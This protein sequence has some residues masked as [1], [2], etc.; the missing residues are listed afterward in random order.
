MPGVSTTGSTNIAVLDSKIVASLCDGKIYVDVTPSIYIGAGAENVLGAN[1][2]ILN[3]YGLAVKPYGDNYEIAPDLSGAMS[4][5]VSFNIPTTAG[6]YQYGKYTVNVKLFDADGSSWVV[7]KY[8]TLCTPDKNNK[9]R[10]Y[11]SLSA[12][13]NGSCTLGKLFIIVDGV[14]TYNGVISES[15]VLS[16]TLEY[17]TSS[18]L[19]P[20]TVTTGNLSVTLFEGVYKLTGEICATYNI[21]DNV[22]QRVKYKVKR[23]KNIRCLIDKCCV[24]SKLVELHTRIQSD[25]TEEERS[26]TASITVDAL[27]LLEMAELA[28]YCG[29]DP[30]EYI[31]D[32]E[33]LL[34]CKCTCNCAE[35][36]PIIGTN[37]SADVVIEG[38]N[39]ASSENG[40]TTTYT[41]NNYE[42]VVG[43][44]DNGGALIVSAGTL[45]GCTVRQVI[46]FNIATVYAQIKTLS[47]QNN[48][49]ADFWA[50]VVNKSLRDVD[51]ASLGLSAVQWQALTFKQKWDAILSKISTC[52]GTCGA[53]IVN[54]VFAQQGKDAVLTWT[55]EAYSYDIY[56]DGL[57]SGTLLTSAYT[58]DLYSH[59][60]YGIADGNEHTWLLIARCSNGAIGET[61]GGAGT[62][63]A[64]RFLGCPDI[65][66]TILITLTEY[67]GGYS[68][69]GDCPYD[70]GGLVDGGNPLTAEWHTANDTSAATLVENPA[71]VSGG[72]YYVFN[73]DANGCYS[74]GTRVSLICSAISSC[75]AP[76]NLTV[77]VFGSSNFFVQFQSAAYPPPAN[78]YTV[79]RR[80]ASAPDTGGSYTT[81]GNPVW[82]ASL[83]RWVIDDLSAINNTVYVYKAESNCTSTTPGVQVS[84]ANIV[85][86]TNTLTPA[87]TSIAYSLV[88][89]ASCNT[90]KVKIYDSTGTVLIHTDTYTPAFANPLTGTFEYLDY[91]TTYKVGIELYFDNGSVDYV[92]ICG[93]QSVTT[94]GSPP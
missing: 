85:C 38:C 81:I 64:F 17:P 70:L 47:N 53:T 37:P 75:T 5:V 42:Y 60:F 9:T 29:E 18:E 27:R 26:L 44:E 4:A 82:N 6:N 19:P 57:L 88:P 68:V 93:L 87:D 90:I 63:G 94:V 2:E 49:E 33:E 91:E 86:P 16:A 20:L 73:K 35:G 48:T 58:A 10:N 22:Y 14:P 40:N 36:T 69:N 30:S 43:I 79:Y 54:P 24:L 92:K 15:Q 71:A 13:L 59:T 61:E 11:G 25:C 66:P 7:T 12:Q 72:V 31:S 41:I 77:G 62:I 8:V 34:G 32:L 89:V 84:Y 28:A 50:S 39:V 46:T 21:G 78:S 1:V 55:G 65:A 3:P 52:C 80:L 23:E 83:N 56:L 76:Q 74:P 45:D 51:P 67:L